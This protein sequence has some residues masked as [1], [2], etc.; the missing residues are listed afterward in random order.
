[1]ILGLSI[2]EIK[3]FYIEFLI[4]CNSSVNK[5]IIPK[6]IQTIIISS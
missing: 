1:M 3:D 6:H 5:K 4:D 2:I